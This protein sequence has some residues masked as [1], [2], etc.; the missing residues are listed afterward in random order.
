MIVTIVEQNCKFRC[1]ECGAEIECEIEEF[2][3]HV[4]EDF[5]NPTSLSKLLVCECVLTGPF[6][7][8]L[9]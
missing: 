3:R 6:S 1:E 9:H 5:L 2:R 4:R 7:R 8:A